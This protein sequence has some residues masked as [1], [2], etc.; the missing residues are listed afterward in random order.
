M[1]IWRKQQ[2]VCGNKK[3]TS[4]E[5]DGRKRDNV[6]RTLITREPSR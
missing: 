5:G 3:E 2:K 6:I 4:Q 1:I